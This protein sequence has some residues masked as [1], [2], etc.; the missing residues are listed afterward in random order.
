MAARITHVAIKDYRSIGSC[1]VELQPLTLLV[2][3]NG[4]GKSNFL[5][6]LRFLHDCMHAPLQQVVHSR[7]GMT[8]ILRRL[9]MAQFA[10]FCT[11]ALRFQLEDTTAGYYSL[12]LG[13]GRDDAAVILEEQ[14]QVGHQWFTYEK[15]RTHSSVGN[16]PP[17]SGDRPLLASFAVLPQFFRAFQ[18]LNSFAFYT[19]TPSQMRQPLLAGPGNLLLPDASNAADVFSRIARNSQLVERIQ[20][21]LCSI[22]PQFTKFD[23]YEHE[24]YRWFQFYP[25]TD[26][27]S[28]WK[29]NGAQVS[30]GTL[31][32]IGVLLAIFQNPTQPL[33]LIGLEEPETNLH[34]AAAGVLLDALLEASN[35]VQIIASTHS[36][37]LLDRKTLPENSILA[38]VLKDGETIIGPVDD[39]SRAILRQRYYTAGGLLRS[40]EL[41]PSRT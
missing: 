36:A 28:G 7:F 2:G 41:Q 39:A 19:P 22:N 6:A 38:V 25:S 13:P 12:S 32:A 20:G 8:S 35:S 10:E 18:L 21:Y 9:P 4:S 33:S 16:L 27:P 23:T 15:G 3:P 29:F 1:D 40:N 34:P 14:C 30:D 11:V 26:G 5:D 17:S 37:D 24:G 31:H